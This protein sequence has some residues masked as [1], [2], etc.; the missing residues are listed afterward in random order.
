MNETIVVTGADGFVGTAL[1]SHLRASGRRFRALTRA[2]GQTQGNAQYLPI[3]DLTTAS[4]DVLARAIEGAGAIVH[5]AARAHVMRE[6]QADA[7]R[8]YREA[9]VVATE[10]L[11]RAAVRAGVP[12]FVF[13]STIKVNGESTV[14]GRP[15]READPPRPGDAYGRSKWDAERML[16][17]IARGSLLM[18]V[19]RPPLIYGPRVRGNFLALWRAVAHGVPLPFARIVDRRHLLY[20]GNLV[21]AIVALI[22]APAYDGGTWL[23]ADREA[24]STPELVRRMG[25]ALGHQARLVPVPVGLLAA[26]AALVGRRTLVPRIAGTLEIDAGALTA[27]IGPLPFTLD[28]GLAATALWWHRRS[29]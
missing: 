9:N 17:D 18:S 6:R 2:L 1:C 19:L 27:R 24:V 16:A 8:A 11:A 10:R 26:G 20:V 28:Q 13:V 29:Q 22:D 25:N 4:D 23:V 21:H 15:F 5:L 3:G 14:P 7:D 12:H